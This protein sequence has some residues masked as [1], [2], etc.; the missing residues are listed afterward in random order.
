[1]ISVVV[2]ARPTLIEPLQRHGLISLPSSWSGPSKQILHCGDPLEGTLAVVAS[3]ASSTPC[4]LA[5]GRKCHVCFSISYKYDAW[6]RPGHV[7]SPFD[8][9]VPGT[10]M[11]I[12]EGSPK[13]W[14][15]PKE[16]KSTRCHSGSLNVF[17]TWKVGNSSR[18]PFQT[19]ACHSLA[20]PGLPTRWHSE[21]SPQIYTIANICPYPNLGIIPL[22]AHV[23]AGF[24]GQILWP[25]F[26]AKFMAS[27]YGQH[28][29]SETFAHRPLL[30]YCLFSFALGSP[31]L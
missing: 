14:G 6:L 9:P 13:S 8:L 26:T 12:E 3:F 1:M 18:V 19:R 22:H 15:V 20:S 21:T 5:A 27:I 29:C 11:G 23:M 25:N 24:Y 31:I 30:I 28:G 16:T 17:G 2:C 4:M 10:T 7:W